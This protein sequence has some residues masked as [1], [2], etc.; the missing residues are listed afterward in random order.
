MA[1]AEPEALT[2]IGVIKALETAKI[3]D[4]C[5]SRDEHGRPCRQLVCDSWRDNLVGEYI[6]EYQEDAIWLRAL[7]LY[8]RR[9]GTL[10]RSP[11]VAE[12]VENKDLKANSLRIA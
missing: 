3:S 8:W 1:A 4:P 9:D 12:A 11:G 2:H 5:D 7:H 10:F 6:P